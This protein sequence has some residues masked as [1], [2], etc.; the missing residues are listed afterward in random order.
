MQHG[1]A[2]HQL[3]VVSRPWTCELRD[4]PSL[5]LK[6]L[7]FQLLVSHELQRERGSAVESASTFVV[8]GIS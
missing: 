3:L 4:V 2:L 7:A 8:E 5:T 1:D 6:C